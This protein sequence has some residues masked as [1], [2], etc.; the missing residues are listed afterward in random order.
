MKTEDLTPLKELAFKYV[1]NNLKED[2]KL[3]D[4]HSIRVQFDLV[5]V[6]FNADIEKRD[7][8]IE[9]EDLGIEFDKKDEYEKEVYASSINHVIR[10]LTGGERNYDKI[11]NI[12][13]LLRLGSIRND[14]IPRFLHRQIESFTQTVT[15]DTNTIDCYY[16]T[17]DGVR[18]L[19]DMDEIISETEEYFFPNEL[20]SMPEYEAKER[21]ADTLAKLEEKRKKRYI[22]ELKNDIKRQEKS[23]AENKKRL[24][25][26]EKLKED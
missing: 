5:K 19:T 9:L 23:L 21:Y 13:F 20:L 17:N 3:E 12:S 10:L 22:T 6:C 2:V 25:E 16:V 15:G 7:I 24:A 1:K 8:F 26:L 14:S 18:V 11:P 4:I